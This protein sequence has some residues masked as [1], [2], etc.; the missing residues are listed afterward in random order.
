VRAFSSRFSAN[1]AGDIHI[2]GNTMETCS[3]SGSNGASCATGRNGTGGV[4]NNN[5]FTMIMVDVDGDASSFNSSSAD[6]NLTAGSSVLFAGLYWS[7]D[8]S[9]G[10]GGAAAPN[11]AL[12]NQVQ[13]SRPDGSSSTV[14]ATQVDLSGTIY[15]SF[16]DVTALVQA[17]GN[18]A[19]TVANLQAGTGANHYGGWSL[20]VAFQDPGEPIRN[21]TVN[22]GFAVVSGATPSV[23]TTIGG[24]LTP[25]T[26]PVRSRLGAVVYEGDLALTGDALRLNGTALSD[27]LNP[28]SN[29][30]NSTIGRLGTR[31]TA[32]SPD[33]VNQL[34]YDSDVIDATG[35]LGNS[36]NSATMAFSTG[37]E[38]FYAGVV[39][40]ATELF[41][42]VIAGNVLKSVS[43]VNG[44]T[45]VPGDTLE[46]SIAVSNT[47]Q[48]GA[49][50][51]V[52]TDTIPANTTFVPGSLEI[53]AGAN[54]GGKT[55]AATDDQAEFD[56]AGNLVVF[57]LG[58]GANGG[59]G[60]L[61]SP[62][63]ATTARFR[64]TV[65]PSVPSGTT[66]P[67]RSD[68]AYNSQ[69]LGTSSSAP[70]TVTTEVVTVPDLAIGVS[71]TGNF[72][73]GQPGSYS[74]IV[75]NPGNLGT[76]GV[77]TVTD[78]LPAGLVPTSAS[79]TGW[80]C[81]IAGQVV[82]CT[83][84]DA[85]AAAGSYPAIAL[86]VTA[87]PDAAPGL[88]NRAHVEGGGETNT[89]NDEAS[90]PTTVNSAPD[91]GIAIS[92]AGGFNIGQNGVFT[93]DLTNVG[94]ASTTGLI[95][96]TDQLPAGL[97][98]VSG[99]GTGWSCTA[100]GQDVT[101]TR[102]A[103]VGP[104]ATTSITLTVSV[105]AG[106]PASVNNSA[107]VATAGDS[108][109]SNDTATDS[110]IPIGGPAD[111]ALQMNHPGAFVV[112]HA[113]TY[114]I[115]AINVG[116]AP[117]TGTITVTDVLPTGLNFTSGSGSGWSCG[118]VGQ[119]VTCTTPG[120]LAAGA[121]S[122]LTLTVAVDASALPG[123]TNTASVATPGDLNSANN[124][125]TDLTTVNSPTL[126][127]TVS[128]SHSGDFTVGG[129]G[130][131]SLVI[132]NIGNLPST[133][134]ITVTDTL[135]AGLSF[136]S[137][138]GSGW[139][140]SAVG[141]VVTCINTG[142][143][144]VGSSNSLTLM[145][146]VTQAGVPTVNHTVHVQTSGD[147]N[148]ANDSS[149]DPTTV[150]GPVDL[151]IAKRHNGNFTVGVNAAY[152]L[153][154]S[155]V[156]PTPSSGT[157]T[158]RDSLPAGLGFVSGT[159]SGW[160]CNAVGALVT[161]ATPGP[162]AAGDSSAISLT[163]SVAAAAMP[164]VTNSASV[165]TPGDSVPSGN[166][167][168]TDVPATVTGQFALFTEKSASRTEAEIGDV[169]DY[170]VR[171]RGAGTS[172]VPAV[173][174]EDRLPH[175]FAYL[176]GSTRIDGATTSDP[177]GSPGPL[178]TFNV[179]QIAPATIVTVSYRARIGAGARTGSN[180]N[181][182]VARSGAVTAVS[183]S[184]VATVQ[185][186]RTGGVF[187][188]RG[189]IAGTVYTPADTSVEGSA[190]T[191]IPGVRVYLEDGTSAL[192]DEEGK[193]H[194]DGV[195]PRLHV[196]KVDRATLPRGAV[197]LVTG[198]RN[199]GDGYTRFVDLTSGELHRADF[200]E[201]SG[202][203]SVR[204]EI[205]QRREGGEEDVA[206]APRFAPAY[207]GLLL[208]ERLSEHTSNL[209]PA[210]LEAKADAEG[211]PV[212]AA[213]TSLEVELPRG[214]IGADGETRVPVEV[215]LLKA[216]G[217]ARVG[218]EPVTLEA[219]LGRWAVPDEDRTEP[220]VQT[221]LHD[222]I[223][224][225][226][227]IAS[228]QPGRGQI[229]ITAGTV[230]RSE[231][232]AFVPA[233]HPLTAA[234]LVQGRLDLR[235]IS[236]DALAP[237]RTEDGFE[238]TLNNISFDEGDLHGAMRSALVLKGKVKGD[239]LLTLAYDTERDPNRT[240]FRDIQPDQFYP[241]YG[242]A[243][244]REFDAQ[245]AQRLY[246]RVDHDRSYL[247]YGDFT[248]TPVD[249]VRELSRFDR[250]LTG[251]VQHV[252]G[253]KGMLDVFATRGQLTQVVDEIPGLGISGPY[254]LSRP[255]GRVNSEKVEII[256]R[257]RNHPDLILQ[258]VRQER[259][260]DYEFEPFTGRILFRAPVP[261][262]DA[263]LNPVSIRVS[264]EVEGGGD[265]FWV[266]GADGRYRVAPRLELGGAFAED[267][268]PLAERRVWGF[269][270]SLQV[271]SGSY[272][273][274]EFGRS[275]NDGLNG[276]A[277]RAEFRHRST[278]LDLR[279]YGARSDSG[280]ANPSSTLGAG[281]L[282]LGLRGTAAIN[283]RT[284][285]LGEALRTEDRVFGGHRD[286]ASLA[287]ERRLSD[288]F[289]A[290]LGYRYGHETVDP[291]SPLTAGATPNE[292]NALRG[293]LTA[294]IPRSRAAVF[295]E[296]EQDVAETDQHRGA[297]GGEYRIASRARLYGRHEW[298]TSLAG[299]YALNGVQHLETTVIGI[300]ADYYRS[301]RV[302][303]EYR[304]RDAFSGRE[305]EAAI[306][307][308]NRWAVA[309]GWFLNTSFERVSPISG[310]G[311]GRATAITGAVEYTGNLLWK[312][313]GRLEYRDS[314]SGDN[315]LGT[316]GYA[317]K[318]S[319]SLSL[320]GRT[321]WNAFGADQWR[322]RSQ[323]GLAVRRTEADRW[324]G[325]VRYEHH[326]ERL[327]LAAGRATHT[328]SVVAGVLNFQ[329]RSSLSLSWRYAG[330]LAG[331]DAGDGVIHSNAQLLMQRA[332]V[333]LTSKWD[334]GLIGS[335]L[336]SEGFDS[337]RY[338][339]GVE[340]GRRLMRNLRVAAGYN[341]FGF[342]DRDLVSSGYTNQGVYLDLG[343]KFD[344][345]LFQKT[346]EP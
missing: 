279:V 136:V 193:Y 64:V 345:G 52:L 207:T 235:S 49:T 127:L 133:G 271:A 175:G 209:P 232:V 324:N 129:Q 19:Y 275:E 208:A 1:Q 218:T 236:R 44:G 296:Y 328:A 274:A 256:T 157:I 254:T 153:V 59:S 60:G 62:G 115:T 226:T 196:V 214:S 80:S 242:D 201:G 246:V 278:G 31:I 98:F 269:N 238:Q 143:L 287:V 317:R 340:A 250:S 213:T 314:P 120:P 21:L 171:V 176:P 306:G 332:I 112:G 130:S 300:D 43:D 265:P 103:A 270:S 206:P 327:N 45:L 182:A 178:L 86:G 138:S 286:G 221:F 241:V 200:V 39:T 109:P 344:E 292:T 102:S 203:A 50:N 132:S 169:V 152:T 262:L 309:P 219:S 198:S 248:T 311:S 164:S 22:D 110:A 185:V 15:Q 177:V 202:T 255:D 216:D 299:P 252:E 13:F 190:R 310:V 20:V 6:L 35:I 78:T 74:I 91:L 325:L 318:L 85:L 192:T 331:D 54:A 116:A 156:G 162:M 97:S 81:G 225:F 283:Q 151:A 131:Y 282:E 166:N 67:N 288:V 125:A 316:L 26:G 14:T 77:V 29:P 307:L 338:G 155:N 204:Q 94:A 212:G 329:P 124:G 71:H 295:G 263:N 87:A 197:L 290:E 211:A 335:V 245:T 34:G 163:V 47:G 217:S 230:S 150:V 180:Q 261:S 10:V 186:G 95:T 179:G 172:A 53:T 27:A 11:S 42:P 66:I 55:D 210:P 315:F 79:G 89:A 168:T 170:T 188:D 137:G 326:F 65:S 330:K 281:R 121:S 18:G 141:Q 229:R 4:T 107:S 243:S 215:R 284:R 205:L 40:I 63:Q 268:N 28:V 140:C 147:A 139:T 145:V 58:T 183:N 323:V 276:N 123:V 228:P 2:I 336:V 297:I 285:L 32:K 108:D 233:S 70:S 301:N 3:P 84:S 101:C 189:T 37:G 96:V 240:L 51:I 191:G 224:K 249:N 122:D 33:Y 313:S 237:A 16:A 222:G 195:S 36:A 312:V 8:L 76:S 73:Q 72:T 159:G 174:V 57:R 119:T 99:T 239:Y 341:V 333:D 146:A 257:D 247:L 289:R 61:L 339:L 113:G 144:T 69:T 105:D 117:T 251:A 165:V 266:Y 38:T 12:R 272:L 319:R 48:D 259:F 303:S 280:F 187:D 93:I 294:D 346:A 337:R 253:R 273:L 167:I 277:Q 308:R 46:Y 161:C 5:D 23:S 24:F 260:N 199:A 148:A 223:G 88:T 92:H 267:D 305:T 56:G 231:A 104:S 154:V 126:D 118:A 258:S 128:G 83:R 220:G 25:A 75:S 227:L 342:S 135:P 302:F 343:F 114:T 184:A 160:A 9:A 111:L 142:V 291:A 304:A 41:A 100:L 82:T 90:D 320:L 106:A 298:I 293:R 321:L 68:V 7:A 194:F 234:G 322:E 17:G 158:V 134:S 173:I 181:L 334:A 264:Y 244:V 30:F 149:S